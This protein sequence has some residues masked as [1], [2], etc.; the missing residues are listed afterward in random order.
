MGDHMNFAHNADINR[1]GLL[2][3]WSQAYKAQGGQPLNVYL[4]HLAGWVPQRNNFINFLN[5]G[6]GFN[7][8]SFNWQLVSNNNKKLLSVIVHYPGT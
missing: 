5:T 4:G 6:N 1:H 3:K 7:L 8:N 2:E